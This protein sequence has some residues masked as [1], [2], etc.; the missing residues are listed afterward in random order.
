MSLQN[1]SAR[2]ISQF[3]RVSLFAVEEMA[4][5]YECILENEAEMDK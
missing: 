3:A 2:A 4:G 5:Q 1:I